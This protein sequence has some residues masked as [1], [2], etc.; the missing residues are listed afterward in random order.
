MIYQSESE[1]R[2]FQVHQPCDRF[3]VCEN[4]K[5]LGLGKVEVTPCGASETWGSSVEAWDLHFRWAK[6]IQDQLRLDSSV[7]VDH[8]YRY[9]YLFMFLLLWL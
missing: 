5:V 3:C 4:E 1:A 7:K 2:H 9:W 8:L 6:N